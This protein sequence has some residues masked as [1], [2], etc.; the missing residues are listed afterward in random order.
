MFRTFPSMFQTQCKTL[1]YQH[2]FLSFCSSQCACY[3]NIILPTVCVI[4]KMHCFGWINPKDSRLPTNPASIKFVSNPIQSFPVQCS[5]WAFNPCSQTVWPNRRH[6][7]ASGRAE[8]LIR[9]TQADVITILFSHDS[10]RGIAFV[11][12]SSPPHL[13]FLKGN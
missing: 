9:G 2:K 10:C 11:L 8:L 1:C 4:Y 7:P 5:H 3:K 12:I 13:L 6:T